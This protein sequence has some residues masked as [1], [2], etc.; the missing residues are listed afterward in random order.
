MDFIIRMVTG[1]HLCLGVRG[2]HL[3]T[4]TSPLFYEGV[5]VHSDMSCPISD[6]LARTSCPNLNMSHV[7]H[8]CPIVLLSVLSHCPPLLQLSCRGG[9]LITLC[10]SVY[11]MFSR[12]K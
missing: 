5:E 12:L 6:V 7:G 8:L 11:L 1:Q 3:G 10:Q 9:I 2:S 4:L